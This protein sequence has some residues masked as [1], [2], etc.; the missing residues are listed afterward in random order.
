MKRM[1]LIGK[2][3]RYPIQS[4]FLKKPSLRSRSAV[5]VFLGCQNL[6]LVYKVDMFTARKLYVI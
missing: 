6:L 4:L 2:M 3:P 5:S 1:V